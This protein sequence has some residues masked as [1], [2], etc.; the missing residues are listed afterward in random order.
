MNESEQAQDISEIKARWF[1]CPKANQMDIEDIAFA[2]LDRE[3]LLEIVDSQSQK[4]AQLT[5]EAR[6][7]DSDSLQVRQ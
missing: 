6:R 3:K 1:D 7:N 2:K 5:K 4:I